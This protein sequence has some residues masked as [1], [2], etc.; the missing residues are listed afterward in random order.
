MINISKLRWTLRT[1]AI[2]IAVALA[3]Q[4]GAQAITDTSFN[5]T[6]RLFGFVALNNTAFAPSNAP[7]IDDGYTNRSSGLMPSGTNACFVSGLTFPNGAVIGA[8]RFWY[9]NHTSVNF[10]RVRFDD[11]TIEMIASANPPDLGADAESALP[12]PPTPEKHW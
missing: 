1:S 2:A 7:A 4:T 5:Y 11:G 8:G 6:R 3:L 12:Y 10:F 9:I